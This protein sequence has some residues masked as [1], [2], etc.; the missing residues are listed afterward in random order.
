MW[1]V[2]LGGSLLSHPLLPDCLA[3]LAQQT[4]VVIVP[5]GGIYADQ[6]RQAQPVCGLDDETAHWLAIAAMN[7]TAQHLHRLQSRLPLVETQQ[8]IEQAQAKAQPVIWLPYQWLSQD[9]T[10]PCGWQVTSDS[11]AAWLAKTLQAQHLLLVKSFRPQAERL[12]V[13]ALQADGVVDDYLPNVLA[14]TTFS[15]WLASIEDVTQSLAKQPLSELKQ[16]ALSVQ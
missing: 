4:N 12:S 6:V 8:E 10:L 5:G 11:I 1:V 13:Q 9:A 2:K 14:A 16:Y 7:Q 3:V 15:T